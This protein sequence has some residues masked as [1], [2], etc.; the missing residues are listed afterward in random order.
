M[1]GTSLAFR[2]QSHGPKHRPLR[3]ER[4]RKS[5]RRGHHPQRRKQGGRRNK[6]RRAKGQFRYLQPW[7]VQHGDEFEGKPSGVAPSK[8]PAQAS[9]PPSPTD[10]EYTTN[11][12]PNPSPSTSLLTTANTERPPTSTNPQKWSR[13]K[14][15]HEVMPTLDMTL[16]DWTDY[17]DM[18]P[19][20]TWPTYKRKG[21]WHGKN[22]SGGNTTADT[23]AVEACDHHLDCLSGSCCDLRDHECRPYNRGL[24]NK[25]YDD[26]MCTEGLRCYAKFHRKRRV[27]R[28]KGR[29][30]E[31]E[32][33]N[34]DQGAFITV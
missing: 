11:P 23:D 15:Q 10:M 31:P 5:G 29:C 13:R 3:T 2:I 33:A 18:R 9:P 27:T 20:E 12:S 26:C 30:V 21:K 7:L 4:A 14:Q 34:S 19:A 16:F 25:C 1:E 22:L 24:N 28:R 17:E 8:S 6:A 32:S